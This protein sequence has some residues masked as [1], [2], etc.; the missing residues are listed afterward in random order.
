[1]F[2]R[3]LWLSALL[4]TSAFAG[5][6]VVKSGVLQ[7]NQVAV[8]GQTTWDRLANAASQTT[9]GLWNSTRAIIKSGS[10]LL[11]DAVIEYLGELPGHDPSVGTTPGQGGV[12]GGSASY[13]I[14]IVLPPGRKGMQ[15]NISLSYSSR[16]DNGIAGMG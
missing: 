6:V 13:N 1:M 10:F 3:I 4:A 12:S 15:P 5:Q 16:G 14:P 7:R 9:Q 2:K 11:P 8:A